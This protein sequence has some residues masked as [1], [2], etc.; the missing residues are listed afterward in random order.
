MNPEVKK[1]IE[2]LK[3]YKAIGRALDGKTPSED[4]S[5]PGIEKTGII[6]LASLAG[7]VLIFGIL[8]ATGQDIGPI[9]AFIIVAAGSFWAVRK[10]N[11]QKL[12]QTIG[13]IT[14]RRDRITQNPPRSFSSSYAPTIPARLANPDEQ[15]DKACQLLPVCCLIPF[16]GGLLVLPAYVVGI[17]AM[18]KGKITQGIT[19]MVFAPI[20]ATIGIFVIPFCFIAVTG[21]FGSFANAFSGPPP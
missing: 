3:Q 19:T 21:F 11:W 17:I 10:L 16:I 8:L 5:R 1:W 7:L 9:I 6:A 2:E 15:L 14:R 20:A 18:T 12:Q 13:K 4:E